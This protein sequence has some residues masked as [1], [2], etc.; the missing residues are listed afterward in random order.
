VKITLIPAAIANPGH[1]LQYLSSTL[2]NDTI[3]LDVGCL[4]FYRS[5]AD[6]A[7][8][9]HVLL[10]HSHLDHLASLPIFLEN[11]YDASGEGVT[12]HASSPVLEACQSDLFNERIWPDFIAL[13][14]A[15]MPFL[16]LSPFEP[17]QTIHLEGLRITAVS[18]SHVVPTVGFLVADEHSTVAFV[19]DTGPTE[20]IW[21][22][23]NAAANV[24]AVFLEATFPSSM[25]WLADVSKHL[26]PPLLALEVQKLT[27]PTR[28]I[29]IHIKARYQPEVI[30][31]L[32]ALHLP[33]LEVGR[34]G[35]PYTF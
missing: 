25:T 24:K 15:G 9:R 8:V 32:E 18:L 33:N 2:L 17:G 10:S 35:R 12:I 22:A 13:S 3:A 27:R 29:V 28:I 4:G 31:E 23:I 30:A 1:D 19:S 20:E 16:K 11:V 14:R 26:T 34:F 5:P 21:S 6:Q 7:R